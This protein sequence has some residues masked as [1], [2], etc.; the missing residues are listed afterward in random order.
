M[1]N[2]EIKHRLLC[3]ALKHILFCIVFLAG[4]FENNFAGEAITNK[5]I[6]YILSKM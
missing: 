2:S 5:D 3:F 6:G 4:L 1:I